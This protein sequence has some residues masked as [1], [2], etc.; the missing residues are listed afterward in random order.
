MKIDIV[1]RKN[2]KQRKLF[3]FYI[4]LFFV[5]ISC[6]FMNPFSKFYHDST[7]GVDLTTSPRVVLPIGDPKIYRGADQDSDFILMSEMGYALVGYSS[8]NSGVI[9]NGGA[10]ETAK[11]V[12]AS[13]IIIYS[14]YKETLTG[15]IP[16]VVPNTQSSM[17]SMNGTVTGNGGNGQ[18]FGTA[19][20]TTY[21]TKTVEIPYSNERFDY[22]A[23]YWIKLKP[24]IL[25][26][27]VSPL[28]PGIR[29]QI[30]SNKGLL[31]RGVVKNS[32]AFESDIIPGDVLKKIGDIEIVDFASF[33]EALL[34]YEG[35]MIDITLW[36][37]GKEIT[38]NIQINADAEHS[39]E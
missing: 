19:S 5:F 31:V 35:Q 14:K 11:E 37:G 32:P 29:T 22:F 9:G 17:S 6:A 36:R 39:Y 1:G 15:S 26:L 12:H 4:F 20:T 34:K 13:V 33:R 27:V 10:I 18:F 16:L 38:K 23:S 28:T 2:I 3:A 8:F 21:G 7:H 30:Q 25:G 24:P